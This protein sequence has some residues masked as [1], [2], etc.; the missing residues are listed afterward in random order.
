MVVTIVMVDGKLENE[1]KRIGGEIMRTWNGLIDVSL[2]NH[3]FYVKEK[4]TK[5]RN[6]DSREKLLLLNGEYSAID[7]R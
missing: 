1:F 5:I 2:K 3:D 6:R 4:Y 7:I